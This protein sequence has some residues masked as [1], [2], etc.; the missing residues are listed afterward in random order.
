MAL[1]K[2]NT[3]WNNNTQL[4]N[5]GFNLKAKNPTFN[6]HESNKQLEFNQN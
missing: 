2:V 3:S 1:Q 6:I 5:L 4:T